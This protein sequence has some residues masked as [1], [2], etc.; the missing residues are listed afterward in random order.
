MFEW[1]LLA[2]GIAGFGTA[3]YLDLKT[4]E[5]PDWLPYSMIVLALAVRGAYSF[6]A[7]DLAII[8][9]SVILGLV[10]MGFGLG[11]YFTKQWGDGDAWLLGAMGFLF[12]DPAGFAFSSVFPFPVVMLFNFFLI[13]FIYLLVYSVALGIRS[14]RETARFFRDLRGDLRRIAAMIVL[15][16][17]IC[18]AMYAYFYCQSVPAM[19][20]NYILLLPPLFIML[21]FFVHYGRFIEKNLFRRKVPAGRLREGDVLVSDKWRGLTKDEIKRLQKKGGHVWIK[22]GVRFAPVFVIALLVTLFYGSLIGFL[23]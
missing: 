10:F 16:S 14:R 19:A 9:N 18:G 21:V 6:I 13:A 20:L 11:L 3:G 4:T 2:V 7:N 22:E 12:P 8:T 17:A 15:F 1:I 5:F 23:V